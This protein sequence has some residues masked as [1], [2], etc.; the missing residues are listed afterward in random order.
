AC[1]CLDS[2]CLEHD[3]H[4]AGSQAKIGHSGLSLDLLDQVCD[5]PASFLSVVHGDVRAFFRGELCTFDNPV[6]AIDRRVFGNVIDILGSI[7]ASNNEGSASTIDADHSSLA[8]LQ[9]ILAEVVY[10]NC[11][12]VTTLARV[13]HNDMGAFL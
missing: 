4:I 12:L 6:F 13:V 1:C 8:H 2:C 7:L 5:L 3:S 10:P 11:R 9:R